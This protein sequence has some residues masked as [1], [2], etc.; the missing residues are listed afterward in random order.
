MKRNRRKFLKSATV[1]TAATAVSPVIAKQAGIIREEKEPVIPAA[2]PTHQQR[3]DESGEPDIATPEY[4]AEEQAKYFVDDP[5]SDFMVDAIKSLGIEYISINA[6]SSF[7]GLQE[8]LINYGGNKNP[9]IL[10]CLHEESA[11][12]IAHGYAKAKG[13]PMAMLCHGTVGI[14][15]GAMAVY[16]AYCDRAPMILF[17]GNYTDEEYRSR[18]VEWSHGAQNAAAPIK[19]YIKFHAAPQSASQFAEDVV[20]AY[21]IATTPPMGPVFISVDKHLQEESMG[22]KTLKIPTLSPTIAP[23][24]NRDALAQAAHGRS[25]QPRYRCRPLCQHACRDGVVD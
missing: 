17:G 12:A 24:G 9:Q 22:G 7:R 20:R 21:K 23:Q 13:K 14:Q 16:N 5:V 8:S 2:P 25:R 3:A 1:A 10:T 15:H 6:G 19:D 18:S 4:S 11:I